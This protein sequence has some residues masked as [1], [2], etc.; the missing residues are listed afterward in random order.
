MTLR[1]ARG[2]FRLWV[3]LS[4]LWIAGLAIETWR[5]FPVD[6]WINPSTG[7]KRLLTDEEVG[8]GRNPPPPG[9]VIDKPPFDPSKAYQ[10]VLDKERRSAIQSAILLAFAPPALMLAFGSALVWAFRGFRPY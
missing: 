1:V 8:L 5:T 10:V 9:F 6:D 3:V 7:T 4:V 2:L